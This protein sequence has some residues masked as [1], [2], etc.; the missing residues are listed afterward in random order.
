MSTNVSS[1]E[2]YF[3]SQQ[4]IRTAIS[5]VIYSLVLHFSFKT[6]GISMKYFLLDE[7]WISLDILLMFTNQNL[8][9]KKYSPTV[10]LS[11]TDRPDMSCANYEMTS[12]INN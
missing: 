5:C 6:L 4:E 1:W 11:Q 2:H 3:Y 9:C 7:Q 12:N 10:F 8:I